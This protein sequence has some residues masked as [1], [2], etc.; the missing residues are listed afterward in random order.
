MLDR[1]RAVG[2]LAA[3]LRRGRADWSELLAEHDLVAPPSLRPYLLSL[4]V[5][6]V[7]PLLVLV[8]RSSDADAND[9]VGVS[10]QRS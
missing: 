3:V 4:L 6:R 8:P 1:G 5:D 10:P 9:E 7:A 2:P